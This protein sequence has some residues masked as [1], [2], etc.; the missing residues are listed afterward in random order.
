MN[1][2]T[3]LLLEFYRLREEIATFC[4]SEEGRDEFLRRIP[5]TNKSEVCRLK[6][7]AA[8]WAREAESENPPPLASWQPVSSIFPL[9]KAEGA[10]ISAESF[11]RLGEFCRASEALRLWGMSEE[12]SKGGVEDGLS[13]GADNDED[14][15]A[16]VR[17]KAAAL[18]DLS[19]AHS[20]IFS[21][22]EPDGSFR[23]LPQL[24]SIRKRIAEI[25]RGIER[26]LN[27]L[28]S[29]PALVPMLQ[30]FLPA[31]RGGRQAL[32][33][34][35]NF[36]GRIPGIVH[37][38]SQSGQTIYIEPAEVVEAG[39]DLVTE[40]LRLEREKIEI[41]RNL[42][43]KLRAFCPSFKAALDTLI[44]FDGLSAACRWGKENACTFALD[45]PLQEPHLS[46]ERGGEPPRLNLVRARHPFLRDKA[47]P[48]DIS[49]PE[50]ASVLV[51]TGPNAGGKTVALKT[52]GLFALTNQCG[53][54]VPAAEG[55]AF[56]VFDFIGC[57]IGDDQ[58]IENSLSTFSARMQNT[59]EM[60]KDAGTESLILLDELGSGTD[61]E[62][63]SALA[64]AFLDT[65]A[66][67][68]SLVIA[69]THHAAIK[70]Y[71]FARAGC[72][73]ASVE[74]NAETLAPSYKIIMG[75][76]GESRAID[77]AERNG[78]PQEIVSAA[79]S[80]L[81]GGGADVS[82]LIQKLN[83]KHEEMLKTEEELQR[84][85]ADLREVRRELDLRALRVKQKELLLRESEFG[86]M[87]SFFL[88]SRKALEKLVREIREGGGAVSKEATLAVKSWAENFESALE[89]EKEAMQAEAA[90]VEAGES[91]AGEAASGVPS[92]AAI[93]PDM[94]VL[95]A[96]SGARG[97]VLRR[98]KKGSWLVETGSLKI[99]V[100]ESRL[101]AISPAAGA[102]AKS[103]KALPAAMVE[104]QPAAPSER[105]A[106]ELRL[107]GM[108]RADAEQALI[109]QLD[110]CVMSGLHEFSII[111]G[112][113]NGVL[114]EA[115]AAVLK[116][117][118]AVAEFHFA[119]P[120]NGGTGKT[121]VRLAGTG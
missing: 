70:H 55:T 51:I 109:H 119:L 20:L 21:V 115:V 96:P 9:L 46:D 47:V 36:R 98:G 31:L 39:N 19:E 61:P 1:E 5:S 30:S 117:N 35:A 57:D 12:N 4:V 33:V 23:D 77:I 81:S 37:E 75:M 84:R 64:M 45:L 52:A 27:A 108:R 48:I 116:E 53:W 40:E 6:R 56:P 3:F 68:G 13:H 17:E 26:R 18:P 62:E 16:S 103:G 100:P 8:D 50:G 59:A 89:S 118:P 94:E 34:K 66:E 87:K 104:F 82:L 42:A 79:R 29:D 49:I 74:F 120:E 25:R 95:V 97:R 78:I 65:L 41:L 80:Y 67:R 121:I 91:P 85:N 43:S 2:K 93:A 101:K 107:L 86:R 69:T 99:P 44:F 110:L 38:V 92:A 88:E 60:L 11:A 10:H 112:K 58:S 22:I 54:P 7:L 90:A 63:G 32:A 102:F 114:Q 111:H 113:G 73:N 76:P 106:F 24:A 72:I 71:G 83:A 28:C 105:P 15:G 14:D